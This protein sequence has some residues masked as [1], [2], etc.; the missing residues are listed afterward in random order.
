M[1]PN[2]FNAELNFYLENTLPFS[3]FYDDIVQLKGQFPHLVSDPLVCGLC[4]LVHMVHLH[5]TCTHTHTAG[6]YNGTQKW[7]RPLQFISSR[8]VIQT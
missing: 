2:N 3:S 4:S 5:H 7:R 1:I 6:T 8:P